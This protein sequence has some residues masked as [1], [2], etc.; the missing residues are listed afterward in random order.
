M[1]CSCYGGYAGRRRKPQVVMVVGRRW[2]DRVNGNT[3]F[4]AS[5]WVDGVAAEG[6][7]YDYGY[8]EHYL[9]MA[10]NKLEEA[11]L[12]PPRER[13]SHGGREAPWRWAERTG[14]RLVNDVSDVRCKRD[15]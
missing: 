9:D 6:I 15:L 11:G 1:P 4:S 14:I 13:H 7:D 8:G 5:M 2:F 12:I 3:Y 10:L